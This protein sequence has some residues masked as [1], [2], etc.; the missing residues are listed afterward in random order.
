MTQQVT[1]T[2]K[3]RFP[4]FS[5]AW[6]EIKLG[7]LVKTI[8]GLTYSP[9]DIRSSGMLVLRSSNIQNGRLSFG[10]NV[11]VDPDLK[12]NL[13]K[14]G[15]IL[16]CVRNGSQKLIGKNTLI[17]EQLTNTTHGAFMTVLRGEQYNFVHKLLQT[18]RY[19]KQVNADLGARIN[20]INNSQLLKYKFYVPE[21]SEQEKIATFL[22]EIDKSIEL[23][24]KKIEL[25]KKYK[26]G[27]LQTLFPRKGQTN[28]ELRFKN[29]DGSSFPDWKEIQLS[30]FLIQKIRAVDT[31]SKTYLGL[32]V[33]SHFK[34]L[35]QR[36]NSEPDK[37]MMD[38]LYVVKKGDLVVNIT[39][40]WEGAVAIA[41]SG[42]DGGLVSHRFPTYRFNE[43]LVLGE[44]FRY[45][46][47]GK[48]FKYDMGL[49]SPGGAGRNRVLSK[50]E[51]LKIVVQAPLIKEQGK[52]ADLLNS[53][54]NEIAD[55]ERKLEQ[56]K[57]FKKALLQQM[58]V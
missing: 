49:A 47:P 12:A 50:K 7:D 41:D 17:T 40:A 3:L 22:S 19:Q 52:I 24:S 32:G 29:D 54:D 56:T 18:K 6:S 35:L 14:V 44:F 27:L 37:I 38:T 42:D 58:F 25:S 48:K 5:D 31:P 11:Y 28:P 39:F 4:G 23:L 51:F 9:K 15:D 2:P 26:V 43:D 33:R 13:S 36:Q 21:H 57:Q 1:K 55:Q 30:K 34:G 46:F 8:N 16:I 45:V 53:I 20:S 10:D